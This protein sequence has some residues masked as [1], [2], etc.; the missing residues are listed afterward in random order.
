MKNIFYLAVTTPLTPP[1][2]FQPCWSTGIHIHFNLFTYEM[3]IVSFYNPFIFFMSF[4]ILHYEFVNSFNAMF[5]ILLL[6]FFGGRVFVILYFLVLSG[7]WHGWKMRMFLKNSK[8]LVGYYCNTDFCIQNFLNLFH[9]LA[10]FLFY[11]YLLVV[12]VFFF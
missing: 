2:C 8:V 12:F 6:C 11:L 10:I 4:H 5:F 9:L 3:Y 7:Q 1:L